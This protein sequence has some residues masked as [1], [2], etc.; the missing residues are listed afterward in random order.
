MT[1]LIR[2]WP[3]LLVIALVF[4]SGAWVGQASGNSRAAKAELALSY[5]ERDAA[6]QV[7]LA[8][9][10]ARDTEHR[11]A[12]AMA[13]VSE[14]NEVRIREIQSRADS[15]AADL[16]AGNLRLRHEIAAYATASLSSEATASGKPDPAAERGAALVAAAIGVGAQC[17]AVQ[18]GLIAADGVGRE[19]APLARQW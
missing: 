1:L 4:A 10:K 5:M 9:A 3:H 17:D 6:Q 18:A 16:L 14:Q 8:E 15:R 13:E 7:A 12:A 19:T 2:Y 11:Q